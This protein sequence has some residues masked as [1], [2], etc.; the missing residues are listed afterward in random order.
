MYLGWNKSNP[1]LTSGTTWLLESHS[2]E[3]SQPNIYYWYY[4]T[5]TL[6]HFGGSE[7]EEWNLRMRDVLVDMQETQGHRAGSWP[8]SR[9]DPYSGPGGRIYVTSLAICTLEVYYRHLPIFKRLELEETA[10]AGR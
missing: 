2:P 4:A 8:A 3:H 5:Q 6:H 1:A 10:S 9:K 7:W